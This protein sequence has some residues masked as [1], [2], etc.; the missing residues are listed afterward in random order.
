[1]LAA[2]FA[3]ILDLIGV[4]ASASGNLVTIVF[5]D[6]SSHPLSISA[7]CA[8]LYSFSIVL[9][10]FFAFVLVFEKLPKRQS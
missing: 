8:G 3:G 6:G 1:M 7:Y 5:Q 9:S 10:A 4:P 2:P